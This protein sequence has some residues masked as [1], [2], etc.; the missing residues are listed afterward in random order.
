MKTTTAG[1]LFLGICLLD[2]CSSG[3]IMLANPRTG[4]TLECGASGWGLFAPAASGMV[5]DCVRRYEPDGYVPV[6]RLTPAERADLE[7]RGVVL[8]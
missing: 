3:R 8:R 4:A 7:R 1:L 2:A 5:D 6:E